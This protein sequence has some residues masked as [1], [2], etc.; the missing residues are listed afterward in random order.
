MPKWRHVYFKLLERYKSDW[1][2]WFMDFGLAI[3]LRYLYCWGYIISIFLKTWFE[4]P[5]LKNI[6]AMEKDF[7]VA[8]L[9]TLCFSCK[10]FVFQPWQYFVF[11]ILIMITSIIILSNLK[12]HFGLE[13]DS[14][15]LQTLKWTGH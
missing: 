10:T 5:G 14:N 15:F 12:S 8:L 9:V 3:F 2:M 4:I 11:D 6:F 7:M 1:Y 13:L